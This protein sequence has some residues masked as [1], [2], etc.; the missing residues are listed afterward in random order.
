MPSWAPPT[1]S[2]AAPVVPRLRT[3][4]S[5]V[6]QR[7][8]FLFVGRAGAIDLNEPSGEAQMDS[9]RK[10]VKSQFGPA[11]SAEL[12]GSLRDAAT[13]LT[14]VRK[15][16]IDGLGFFTDTQSFGEVR[17]HLDGDGPNTVKHLVNVIIALAVLLSA[18]LLLTLTLFFMRERCGKTPSDGPKPYNRWVH[19]CAC[20]SWCCSCRFAIFAFFVGGIMLA[21]SVPLAGMCLAMD[22][23]DSA[24]LADMKGTLKV[25]LTGD[26]GKTVNDFID[27]CLNPKVRNADA[28]LLDLVSVGVDA[29][30]SKVTL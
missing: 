17:G 13:P 5:G 6:G 9:F 29:N 11:K 2:C 21:V 20:C 24:T 18:L 12:K 14:D 28:S 7:L 27:V 30:N 23:L 15:L 10:E 22:D 16:L 26:A 3:T 1:R 4:T 25:N 8:L 19:R